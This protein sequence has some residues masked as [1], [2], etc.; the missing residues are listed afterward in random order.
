MFVK[1]VLTVNF[2]CTG[3]ISLPQKCVCVCVCVCV[4]MSTFPLKP[5]TKP[6]FS[7]QTSPNKEVFSQT[8]FALRQPIVCSVFG[9][10][11][12]VCAPESWLLT[13]STSREQCAFSAPGLH[14]SSHLSLWHI[15]DVMFFCVILT[16]LFSDLRV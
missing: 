6:Y 16:L 12:L 4:S 14:Y 11:A 10:M 9:Q 5:R 8:K 1:E 13:I 7:A 15:F 2:R 3:E